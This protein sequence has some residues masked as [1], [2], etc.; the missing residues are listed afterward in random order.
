M[1]S[2]VP[3]QAT[4]PHGLLGAPAPAPLWPLGTCTRRILC[5]LHLLK[6]SRPYL[7]VECS[8][9]REFLP[10]GNQ[11][12]GY[13]TRTS[14]CPRGRLGKSQ[15]RDLRVPATSVPGLRCPDTCQPPAG[16]APPWRTELAQQE[17]RSLPSGRGAGSGGTEGAAVLGAGRGSPTPT[18][19]RVGVSAP[20]PARPPRT[21]L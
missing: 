10:W 3:S 20:S 2:A 19:G 1:G 15:D 7:C 16:G 9:R 8:H 4:Q 17:M 14:G 18:Q 21:S 13:Q 11:T 5:F 6:P 12:P